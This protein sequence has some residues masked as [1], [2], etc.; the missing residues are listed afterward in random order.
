MQPPDVIVFGGFAAGSGGATA[1]SGGALVD[2]TIT[3]CG[4]RADGGRHKGD[5]LDG[6]IASQP[7]INI[8]GAAAPP[9]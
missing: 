8:I 9:G 1:S 2:T 5:I 4:Y 7:Q 3:G 6:C